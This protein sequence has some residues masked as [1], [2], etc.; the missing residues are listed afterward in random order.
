MSWEDEMVKHIKGQIEGRVMTEE[1]T[2]KKKK[3][4]ESFTCVQD[5]VTF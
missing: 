5:A 1:K 3:T 4:P 2:K